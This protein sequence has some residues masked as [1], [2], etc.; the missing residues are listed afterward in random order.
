MQQVMLIEK[1]TC[2]K[3]PLKNFSVS[4]NLKKR[5]Q[6]FPIWRLHKAEIW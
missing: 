4:I 2:N 5:V 6:Q 3:D 1:Q